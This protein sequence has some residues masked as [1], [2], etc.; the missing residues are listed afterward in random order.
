MG[1]KEK[2]LQAVQALND[3]DFIRVVTSEGNSRNVP[4]SQV[5]GGH[6]IPMGLQIDGGD[7]TL[8]WVGEERYADI[9]AWIEAGELVA[10][11]LT[12][13]ASGA[14]QYCYFA[15][16]FPGTNE[17]GFKDILTGEGI[18]IASDNTLTYV[19]G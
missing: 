7:Y 18:T 2:D 17:L 10:I 1:I 9:L 13:V 19:R 16:Y 12:F 15:Q 5:G 8:Q 6:V 4:A 3:G 11:K 14:I